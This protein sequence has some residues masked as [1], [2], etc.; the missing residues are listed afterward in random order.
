MK[1]FGPQ[2]FRPVGGG[3]ILIL[4]MS[5]KKMDSFPTCEFKITCFLKFSPLIFF[6]F[7]RQ[8]LLFELFRT[9]GKTIQKEPKIY[10]F[11]G[12]LQKSLFD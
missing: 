6:R 5:P 12:K 4:G 11:F 9:N 8:K 7:F 3:G 1:F 10:F 2:K